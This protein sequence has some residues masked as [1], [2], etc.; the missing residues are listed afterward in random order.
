[1]NYYI[2]IVGTDLKHVY[3]QSA[4]EAFKFYQYGRK[5]LCFATTKLNDRSSRSHCIFTIYVVNV[6]D[7]R[8]P[9]VSKLV[10]YLML[11][12]M[13]LFFHFTQ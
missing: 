12:F 8:S 6:E 9:A 5:N 2:F 1:M 3:V 10:K 13:L 11:I 7:P 4:E